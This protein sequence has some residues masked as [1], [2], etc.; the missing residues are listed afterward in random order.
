MLLLCSQSF[1]FFKQKTAYEMRISDW[2]SDVCSSDLTSLPLGRSEPLSG[3]EGFVVFEVEI[4]LPR[5]LLCNRLQHAGSGAHGPHCLL[6]PCQPLRLRQ[7]SLFPR[8]IDIQY[9]SDFRDDAVGVGRQV[10]LRD[11][12]QSQPQIVRASFRER[13][14]TYV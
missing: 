12:A 11:L 6:S 9:P 3:V 7:R 14:F 5:R 4:D 8:G 1:F 13:V 10:M 2:S